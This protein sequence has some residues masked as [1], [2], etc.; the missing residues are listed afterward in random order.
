MPTNARYYMSR[1]IKIAELDNQKLIAAIE[2]PAFV[3]IR[4]NRYTFT[5]FQRF[6]RLIKPRGF[7]LDW[8]STSLKG[9]SK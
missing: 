6:G 1:V 2:N 9:R 5:D 4:G 8:R 7:L 3:Q